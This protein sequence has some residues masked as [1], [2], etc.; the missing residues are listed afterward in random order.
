MV[1]DEGKLTE[2]VPEGA[3]SCLSVS[4]QGAEIKKYQN[5]VYVKILCIIWFLYMLQLRYFE[6]VK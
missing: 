5:P 2:P 6:L 1:S 3:K 4:F